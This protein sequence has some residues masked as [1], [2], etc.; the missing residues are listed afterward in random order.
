[1]IGLRDGAIP[2]TI[3]DGV[4]GYVVG[5]ETPNLTDPALI[6]QRKQR[7][8]EAM[9]EGYN[10]LKD[11][12]IAPEGCHEAALRFTRV[13]MAKAYVARYEEVLRGDEW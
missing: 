5:E 9:V 4:N 12:H 13:E 7:D 1:V 8:V 6:L 10:R 11:K 2:E 3:Q